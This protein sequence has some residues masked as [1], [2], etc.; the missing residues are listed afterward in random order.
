MH[1]HVHGLIFL[2]MFALPFDILS[3]E[4][5]IYAWCFN[6]DFISTYWVRGLV[7]IRGRSTTVTWCVE[8]I[9]LVSYLHV[10]V[11]IESKSK[12]LLMISTVHWKEI[13]INFFSHAGISYPSD[14]DDMQ[15][16]QK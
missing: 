4:K 8:I 7:L 9:T 2:F 16:E 13:I 5:L 6:R 12:D 11:V 3:T 15:S 1:R 10:G 14:A